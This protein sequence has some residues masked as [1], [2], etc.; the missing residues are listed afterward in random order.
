MR[1]DSLQSRYADSYLKTAV[2]TATPGQLTLML[3]DGALKF[4]NQARSGFQ[5][6]NDIRRCEHVH[7]AITRAQAIVAELQHTLNLNVEGRLPQTLFQLYD[8]IFS[9]LQKANLEKDPAP[10][11]LAESCLRPIRDSW[12][13][14]LHKQVNEAVNVPA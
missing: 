9:Q 5:E 8:Y 10:L 7:N 4:I 11:D 3:F 2:L 12:A 13:A 1:K 14:M 6:N